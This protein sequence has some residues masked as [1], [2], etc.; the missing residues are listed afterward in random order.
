MLFPYSTERELQRIPYA[1]ISLISANVVVAGFT[2]ANSDL[3]E[4]LALNPTAFHW[5]QPLTAMFT[6]AGFEHIIGNMVVLWVFGSHVEDTVGIAKY[7]LL[8][9]TAGVAADLLQLGGDLV[10]LGEIR[11]GLG[12][13]GCIMGLVSIFA[14]RYRHVKVN[15]FY[16]I[17]YRGGTWQVDA[18]YVAGAYL[19]LDLLGGTLG[20]FG[21]SDGVGHFAHLGGFA[22]GVGWAFALG[23]VHEAAR[24]DARAE[25]HRLSASGAYGAAASSVEAALAKRPN[26]PELHKEAAAYFGLE[27]RSRSKAVRHWGQAIRLWL[28]HGERELALDEWQRAKRR[29][30]AAEFDPSL[31]CGVAVALEADGLFAEALEAYEASAR[32]PSAGRTGPTAALRLAEL[33]E[34]IGDPERARAWYSHLLSHWPDSP[35]ALDAESALHH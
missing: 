4:L 13:S 21:A 25:V 22:A 1:T 24:D 35:E 11:G 27:D 9:L 10:A 23:L 34:R 29:Y 7:L 15:I 8:Y 19:V 12:A 6:H 3:T 33:L 31:L 30:S 26:D 18:M 28:A 14:T 5:W 16:L 17:W 20:F 32:H 2:F